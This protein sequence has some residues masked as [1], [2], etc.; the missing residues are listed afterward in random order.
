MTNNYDRETKTNWRRGRRW[1]P[2]TK[3]G[4]QVKR[5]Y[6]AGIKD[7]PFVLLALDLVWWVLG[8]FGIYILDNWWIGEIASHSVAFILFMAFYAY[9][10]KYCLYSWVCIVGLGL[11]NITNILHYFVNFDYVQLYAGLILILSISFA[12]IKWKQLYYK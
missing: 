9:A 11:L 12:L 7:L 3:T 10:H 5:I 4:Q 1:S 2:E 8:L 6:K